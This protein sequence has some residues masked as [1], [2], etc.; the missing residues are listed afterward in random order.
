MAG[1]PGS[2]L[3]VGATGL[4]GRELVRRLAD[5]PRFRQV[6][7]LARRALPDDLRSVT[8]RTILGDFDR[9]EDQPDAFRV[10]HVFCALGTTIK[11]AGSRER[12][13]Q[14]DFGYP[15]KV[16]ELARAAGA[17]HYLLVS[18]VGADRR[19]RVFYSRVKGELEHAI[20][21]LGFPS[22]TVIRPSLLLGDRPEFRLGEVI[23]KR[24]AWTFPRKYRAV[25]VRDVARLMVAA[26]LEGRPGVRIVENREIVAEA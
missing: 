18:S 23:A 11:L 10:T 24:L 21:D 7:V 5:T 4:V 2:A 9:L 26:A 15:S 17:G 14:I 6:I 22:V 25:H 12:F 20:I 3:V 1:E 19:S 8:V 16:G 13:R